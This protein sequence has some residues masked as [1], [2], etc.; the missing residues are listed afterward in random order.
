MLSGMG[1][2][3]LV[4]SVLNS[5]PI[6]MLACMNIPK[7]IMSKLNSLIADFVWSSKLDSRKRHWVSFDN[8]SKPKFEGGLGIRSF[9]ELQS[10]FRIK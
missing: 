5:I 3:V 1:R 2:I 9:G 8:I 6:H 4:Q 7:G 10:A